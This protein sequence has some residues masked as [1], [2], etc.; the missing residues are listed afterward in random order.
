VS[1]THFWNNIHQVLSKY[2][3]RK[4]KYF[5]KCWQTIKPQNIKN[6]QQ[7]NHPD[8]FTW[9]LFQKSVWALNEISTFLLL[10]LSQQVCWWTISP[11]ESSIDVLNRHTWPLSLRSRY[12]YYMSICRLLFQWDFV[13]MIIKKKNKQSQNS[14][15]IKSEKHDNRKK[16]CPS[17]IH[18][19]DRSFS[20]LDTGI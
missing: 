14:F 17:D 8:S 13:V 12:R 1:T 20:W 5:I 18:A 6:Q 2:K 10:S 7:L 3:E 19:R 4:A 9:M 15:K 11:K 16:W